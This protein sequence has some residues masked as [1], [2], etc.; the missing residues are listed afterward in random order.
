M[1]NTYSKVILNTLWNHVHKS[2]YDYSSILVA[3]GAVRNLLI[4]KKVND[5]D[6]YVNAN[7]LICSIEELTDLLKHL[8]DICQYNGYENN[9]SE[10]VKVINIVPFGEGAVPIDIIFTKCTALGYVKHFFSDYVSQMMYQPF[11]KKF[12]IR[13]DGIADILNKEIRII[14]PCSNSRIFKLRQL[15]EGYT[16]SEPKVVDLTK[17]SDYINSQFNDPK[18]YTHWVEITNEQ[19]QAL[20]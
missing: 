2:H 10:I 13:V 6:I 5:I 16:F 3:G 9:G 14:N 18:F 17:A 15:F 1:I 7:N 8:G 12:L 11:A 4:G 19:I 20:S